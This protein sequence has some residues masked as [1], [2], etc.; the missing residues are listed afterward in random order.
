MQTPSPPRWG[1]PNSRHG[2]QVSGLLLFCS[3]L[4]RRLTAGRL[5]TVGLLAASACI[6]AAAGLVVSLVGLITHGL[7]QLPFNLPSDARLSAQ[8]GLF[9]PLLALVPVIGGLL[10]GLSIV[11]S[12]RF[13][14]RPPVDPIE[15]NALHG[16]Q[17]SFRESLVVTTQIVIS[18]GF[19]ASV[20]SRPAIP[21]CHRRW[22]QNWR[23]SFA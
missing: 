20:A 18:S 1:G 17:M 2:L 6:G 15:A 14:T 21:R 13:R 9:S 4:I 7:H 3:V 5:R 23:P 19:G 16:G 11:L 8:A 12:R 10:V 22:R